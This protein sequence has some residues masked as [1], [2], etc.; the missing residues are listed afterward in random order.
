MQKKRDRLEIIYS[1]LRIIH[2]NKNSIRITPLLRFSNIS[3]QSFSDYYRELIEKQ[4]I[5]EEPDKK[6]KK[7]ISLT[8][9][10]FNFLEK[11]KYILEFIEEFEL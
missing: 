4:L 2:D 9:K 3:S 10:G 7:Y 11:Y 6:G 5:R 1:I 8:D